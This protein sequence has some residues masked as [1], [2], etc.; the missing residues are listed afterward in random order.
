MHISFPVEEVVNNGSKLM[1][2]VALTVYMSL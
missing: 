2:S 1:L